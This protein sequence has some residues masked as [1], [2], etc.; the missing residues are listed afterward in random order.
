MVA[1]IVGCTSAQEPVSGVCEK[2]SACA[3][4]PTGIS[5]ETCVDQITHC[6]TQLADQ[7]RENWEDWTLGCLEKSSCEDF[8]QCYYTKNTCAP[9]TAVE[10]P[11][12]PDDEA[13]K[14][15]CQE[16]DAFECLGLDLIKC[17]DGQWVSESCDD[18]CKAGRYDYAVECIYDDVDRHDLC[19]CYW[20]TECS[21]EQEGDFRCGGDHYHLACTGGEWD[22]VDC[23]DICADSEF[24]PYFIECGEDPTDGKDRC[25][26]SK[27]PPDSP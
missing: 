14:N 5:F 25:G 7:D 27:T 21:D 12:E 22:I 2:A 20:D 11:D 23:I 10:E 6:S 3:Y 13:P 15:L 16:N 9:V 4:L 19:T 26:C 1:T 24:G 18:I 8:A 17:L